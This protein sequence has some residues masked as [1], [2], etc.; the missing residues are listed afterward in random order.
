M[1]ADSESLEDLAKYVGIE[2]ANRV[3][4]NQIDIEDSMYILFTAQSYLLGYLTSEE[5]L[6]YLLNTNKSLEQNIIEIID[7]EIK[8]SDINLFDIILVLINVLNTVYNC[9]KQKENI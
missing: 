9:V 8:I 5:D 7:N 2:L 3:V 4:N 6:E 1:I